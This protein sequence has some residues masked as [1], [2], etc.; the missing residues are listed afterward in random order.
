MRSQFVLLL[1][2]LMMVLILGSMGSVD[3]VD[4]F[5]KDPD[6]VVSE[7]QVLD[8][9]SESDPNATDD[10]KS[11]WETIEAGVGSVIS[12][13]VD[14]ITAPFRAFATVFENWSETISG[15]LGLLIAG[16]VLFLLYLLIR[17]SGFVD[18]FLDRFS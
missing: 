7:V 6:V 3:G 8:V 13:I 4:T 2:V 14:L 1:P 10:D 15:P 9:R 11:I 18:M 5:E 12:T 16:G 17:L